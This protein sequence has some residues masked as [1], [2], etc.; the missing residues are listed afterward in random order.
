MGMH[1]NRLTYLSLL[2]FVTALFIECEAPVEAPRYACHESMH[3]HVYYLESEFT[4]FEVESI[5][6]RKERLLKY[7]NES[8][9]VSFEKIIDA[10]LFVE[11]YG[12]AWA[13]NFRSTCESR[14]YVLSDV[15]HEIIHV[16]VDEELGRT[17]SK[18]L[19]EGFAEAF[20]LDFSHP[21]ERFVDYCDSNRCFRDSTAIADQLIRGAFDHSHLSYIRAGAFVSYLAD[22][23]GILKTK[24]FYRASTA[25]TGQKLAGDY[26]RIFGSS[27]DESEHAFYLK[28]FSL[29]PGASV[30]K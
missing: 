3:F 27:V 10:Y 22:A 28:H 18:F 21:I 23:Y 11:P 4:V 16:V 8:L 30:K 6:E 15:G 29:S 7:I 9:E 25:D 24:D 13:S 2:L 1:R 17:H 14:D 26:E 19:T 5:A 12:R 20:Q